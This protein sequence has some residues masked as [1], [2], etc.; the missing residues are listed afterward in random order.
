MGMRLI[1]PVYLVG[2]QDFNMV[3]LD[4][5]AN[6]CNTYLL[7]TGDPLV[8]MDCGCGESLPGI[9]ENLREM[10]LDPRDVSRVFL[11]HAHLPHAGAAEDLRRNGVEVVA[12]PATAAAVREGGI[13]T[14]AYHYHRRFVRVAE[15]TAMAPEEEVTIGACTIRAVPLPGHSADSM[16]WEATC[17]GR[18]ML[19]CG[20]AVRSPAIPQ[21]RD[22]LDY[23]GETYARTLMGLLDDPPDVLY[24][25]HGP[26]CLSKTEHW[27]AE[28][29]RKL[30][31]TPA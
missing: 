23:D 31:G 9:L 8:L 28:E 11:T 7:N 10:G 19:F 26:F 6:D 27:I 13:A 4:W 25:G 21:H 12:G 22:R 3:Y 29:L 16:G 18:R 20:D 1:G 15:V 2:G 30:L 5:P 17:E 14:A 24:P